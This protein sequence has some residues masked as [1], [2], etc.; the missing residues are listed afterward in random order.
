MALKACSS[1]LWSGAH[2]QDLLEAIDSAGAQHITFN[3]LTKLNIQ[4]TLNRI[5]AAE[6]VM[7]P[8]DAVSM[9]AEAAN[10][11]LQHAT[12]S[13]Q[14]LSAG[15]GGRPPLKGGQKKVS[16]HCLVLRCSTVSAEHRVTA[17]VRVAHNGH[18]PERWCR[19][20]RA[21]AATHSSI[22]GGLSICLL[23][24][25]RPAVLGLSLHGTD[26]LR[27]TFSWLQ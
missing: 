22:A 4:K 10:G 25:M 11:D 19:R 21:M 12:E 2:P 26:L 16:K 20:R 14:W 6:G 9:L 3:P 13:L 5:A 18:R 1:H 23:P 8:E 17:A 27:A 15:N 7:L 24:I